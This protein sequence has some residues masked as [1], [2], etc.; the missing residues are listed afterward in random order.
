MA[1]KGDENS[2][3]NGAKDK[4]CPENISSH[5]HALKKWSHLNHRRDWI[6]YNALFCDWK[7]K[8]GDDGNLRA[9][10]FFSM[11]NVT[12]DNNSSPKDDVAEYRHWHIAYGAEKE[13]NKQ[14]LRIKHQKFK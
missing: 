12:C 10:A 11:F 6:H 13:T 1:K 7:G 4:A 3:P 8:C 9:H 5:P 2:D 14:N